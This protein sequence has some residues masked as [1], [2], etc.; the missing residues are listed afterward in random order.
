MSERTLAI[1]KPIGEEEPIGDICPY[2]K[3]GEALPFA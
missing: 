1:I 3:P 2:D